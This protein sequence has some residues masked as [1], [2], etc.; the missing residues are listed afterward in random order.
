MNKAAFLNIINHVSS[1]SEQEVAELEKLAASFPYCQTAHLLLAKAAYDHGSMLSNQRIRRAAAC[2]TN[3]QLLKKLIYTSAPEL[4]VAPVEPASVN[5]HQVT[6]EESIVV[7]APIIAESPEPEATEQL[8]LEA[9]VEDYPTA[10]VIEE[11]TTVEVENES[12]ADE[13]II[14]TELLPPLETEIQS[15]VTPENFLNEPAAEIIIQPELPAK[16]EQADSVLAYDFFEDQDT[17]FAIENLTPAA[18]YRDPVAD[19]V[20]SLVITEPENLL[21]EVLTNS[22]FAP[23]ETDNIPENNKEE[24]LTEAEPRVITAEA[25][26][27]NISSPQPED[28]DETLARFDEY[29]FKPEKDE[30]ELPAPEQKTSYKEEIVYKVFRENELGY[31]MAS[32]RLGETIQLKDELTPAEPYYFQPELILEYSKQ[33]QLESYAAPVAPSLN[34][35][36]DIIDQFLRQN[37]KLK[38]MANVKIKA[39]PQEDLSSKSTKIKKNMASETLANILV[40]QGKIKKAVKIYEH[41]ILKIPE[42]KAY[43]A[44]QIEKLQ[45]LT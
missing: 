36:F 5:Q 12:P 30:E 11:V 28:A 45:K 40:K 19:F 7:A 26:T 18:P 22:D 24:Y 8:A 31:W 44:S 41:L 14:A 25:L 39:E 6:A 37:P 4:V 10:E 32:S 27:E 9:V 23:A 13:E 2:A 3:R 42:K 33:H 35:Q 1:I 15:A 43:F 17:L 38:S 34:P 21:A 20:N 29:L 16:V